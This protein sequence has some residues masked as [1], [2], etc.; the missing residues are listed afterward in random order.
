MKAD[1]IKEK[2]VKRKRRDQVGYGIAEEIEDSDSE[3][4]I[5]GN[6]HALRQKMKNQ[7]KKHIEMARATP[8]SAKK[9]D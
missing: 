8:V 2:E 4:E 7:G 1:K 3:S 6:V 9:R 5:K